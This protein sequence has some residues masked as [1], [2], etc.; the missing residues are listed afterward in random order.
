MHLDMKQ[1]GWE[2]KHSDGGVKYS[3]CSGM[4]DLLRRGKADNKYTYLPKRQ[5]KKNAHTYIHPHTKHGKWVL[6]INKI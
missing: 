3:P 4:V 2:P 6:Q 1:A 5:I